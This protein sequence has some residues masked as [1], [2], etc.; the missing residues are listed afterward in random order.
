[1]LYFLAFADGDTD[2]LTRIFG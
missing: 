1:M 2:C